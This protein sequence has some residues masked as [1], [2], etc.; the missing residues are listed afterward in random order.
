MVVARSLLAQTLTTIGYGDITPQTT[1][2]RIVGS[3]CMIVAV[4]LFSYI[5]ARIMMA[6][7]VLLCSCLA[8]RAGSIS[9]RCMCR[10]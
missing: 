4:S 7:A 8:Q 1:L 10:H 6:F 5:G 2:E 9:A 3:A